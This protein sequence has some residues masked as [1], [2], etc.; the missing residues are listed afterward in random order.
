MAG[1]GIAI[2][3]KRKP[4]LIHTQITEENGTVSPFRVGATSTSC[5]SIRCLQATLK[6]KRKER[7]IPLVL[8]FLQASFESK[9]GMVLGCASTGSSEA[10]AFLSL[11]V[12]V[13]GSA[14]YQPYG[15]PRAPLFVPSCDMAQDPT[16]RSNIPM[17]ALT[18]AISTPTIPSG[19]STTPISIALL[20]VLGTH[21]EEYLIVCS[22]V[23]NGPRT[24]S[25]LYGRKR[26]L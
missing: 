15:R 20:P 11:L 16:P 4:V 3:F 8:E 22:K 25:L 19:T 9:V 10:G 13:G 26:F 6:G 24:R 5:R 21:G 12:P 7:Y 1:V 2:F 17:F 23:A 18:A 14:V